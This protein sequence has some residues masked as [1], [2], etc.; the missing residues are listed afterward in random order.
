MQIN[1]IPSRKDSWALELLR[2]PMEKLRKPTHERSWQ[3]IQGNAKNITTS[4]RNMKPM[5]EETKKIILKI[6]ILKYKNI[7]RVFIEFVRPNKGGVLEM[8]RVKQAKIN[9]SSPRSF[10]LDLGLIIRIAVLNSRLY[11]GNIDS[12][13]FCF[14]PLSLFMLFISRRYSFGLCHPKAGHKI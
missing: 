9:A 8:W 12:V 2:L 11:H 1:R 7:P 3:T 5:E 4:R 10:N 14:K 13:L 6:L